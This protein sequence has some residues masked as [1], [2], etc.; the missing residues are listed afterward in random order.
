MMLDCVSSLLV[1]W[2]FKQAKVRN[3]SDKGDALKHKLERDAKR[4]RNSSLGIGITFIALACVLCSSAIWKLRRWDPYAAGH[5][6][7][8]HSAA[9]LGNAIAW[10]SVLIFGGL[11]VAKVALSRK[12]R[13]G[14]LWK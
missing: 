14:V 1:F 11:A 10:P 3:F 4:E 8:E 5:L 6:K 7:K 9:D 2:R 13:S 12:L